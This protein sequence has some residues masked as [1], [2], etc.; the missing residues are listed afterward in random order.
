MASGCTVEAHMELKL[1]LSRTVTCHL[2]SLRKA[3]HMAKAEQEQPGEIAGPGSVAHV[4][5]A[6]HKS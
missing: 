5:S 3:H 4:C 2:G 1:E 6:H